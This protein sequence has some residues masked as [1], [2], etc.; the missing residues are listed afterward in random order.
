MKPKLGTDDIDGAHAKGPP[1]RHPDLRQVR[2]RQL[3]VKAHDCNVAKH[4]PIP[5][6]RDSL[7][8]NR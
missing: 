2:V 6:E 5:D 7:R 4:H 8:A 1:K 3:R